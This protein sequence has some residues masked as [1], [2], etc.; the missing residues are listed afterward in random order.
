MVRGASW[1]GNKEKSLLE[2]KVSGCRINAR[3]ASA[4][5]DSISEDR[6]SKMVSL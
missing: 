6:A 5:A 1:A 4:Y 2:T 3:E